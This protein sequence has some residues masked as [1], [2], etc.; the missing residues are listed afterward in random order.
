M[1]ETTSSTKGKTYI[2]QTVGRRKSSVARVY[3]APGQG[4][5]VINRREIGDYF[6]KATNR[7]A[8][9]QPLN[10]TEQ[11]NK[12]DI[13]VNVRGGGTTGQAGAIRLGIARALLKVKT[14]SNGKAQKGQI[15]HPGFSQGRA[16]K[17][18]SAWGQAKIPVFQAIIPPFPDSRGKDLVCFCR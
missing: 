8:V 11:T 13:L 12:Y 16:E 3:I 4:K 17:G 6:S 5:I 1:A 10:L 2:A 7:Y 18:R 14:R 15:P 9:N